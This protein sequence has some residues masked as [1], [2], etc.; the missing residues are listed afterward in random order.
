MLWDEPA[1]F[2]AVGG[3]VLLLLAYVST[4]EVL[5]SDA[6]GVFLVPEMSGLFSFSARRDE[7][8]ADFPRFA[9]RIGATLLSI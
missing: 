9:R 1:M 2:G 8:S 4:K 6:V 5:F 3:R 7:I